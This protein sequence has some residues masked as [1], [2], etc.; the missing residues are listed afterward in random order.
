MLVNKLSSQCGTVTTSAIALPSSSEIPEDHLGDDILSMFT[1]RGFIPA[2]TVSRANAVAASPSVLKA[3]SPAIYVS[4]DK[5]V[6]GMYLGESVLS[7]NWNSVTVDGMPFSEFLKCA[8]DAQSLADK[9]EKLLRSASEYFGAK[10]IL[11]DQNIQYKITLPFKIGKNSF[12]VSY[13][14]K[15]VSESEAYIFQENDS[16]NFPKDYNQD[17]K[18][19]FKNSALFSLILPT[20][21]N[22][23]KI[24]NITLDSN[25][26]SGSSKNQQVAFSWN[27]NIFSNLWDLLVPVGFSADFGNNFKASKSNFIQDYNFLGKV[28]FSAIN[29]FGRDSSLEL[30]NWY[31][32]EEIVSNFSANYVKDKWNFAFNNGINVFLSETNSLSSLFESKITLNESFSIF[33][34]VIWNRLGKTAYLLPLIRIFYEDF[35]AKKFIRK[36]TF[37]FSLENDHA[38]SKK[39]FT[40]DFSHSVSVFVTDFASINTEIYGNMAKTQ[41]EKNEKTTLEFSITLSGKLIF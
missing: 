30:F 13:G 15:A 38:N 23:H 8:P 20:N 29:L 37:S 11:L 5:N 28:S 10:A 27:R 3:P 6:S 41:Q 19:F 21:N 22:G 12:S 25:K 39:T 18:F 40:G 33:E 4:I 32:F 35:T 14:E 26:I 36:E 24:Q 2:V 34:S 31:S 1:R 9:T 7:F 16:V 17:F